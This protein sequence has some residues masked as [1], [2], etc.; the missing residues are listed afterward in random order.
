MKEA[1]ISD[2]RPCRI[3]ATLSS[4][5]KTYEG[6]TL[7]PRWRRGRVRIRRLLRSQTPIFQSDLPKHNLGYQE[8]R[9]R[10]RDLTYHRRMFIVCPPS[11]SIQSP[12]IRNFSHP[13]LDSNSSSL[14]ITLKLTTKPKSAFKL[15]NS[16]IMSP[17]SIHLL[18]I[19][20]T[21]SIAVQQ[22]ESLRV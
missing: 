16:N 12:D 2:A 22:G 1:S 11:N 10:L 8:T 14:S 15:L 19:G 13:N 6:I 21:L 7:S 5:V 4:K 9:S 17:Q 3:K 20:R 18:I